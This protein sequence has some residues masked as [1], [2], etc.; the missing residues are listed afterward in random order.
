MPLIHVPELVLCQDILYVYLAHPSLFF[1]PHEGSFQ[2]WSDEPERVA[3]EGSF[4]LIFGYVVDPIT[5]VTRGPVR[6]D[7]GAGGRAHS[8]LDDNVPG[9]FGSVK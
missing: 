9:K 5:T 3:A 2:S 8:T 6:D 1:D 4:G 7:I